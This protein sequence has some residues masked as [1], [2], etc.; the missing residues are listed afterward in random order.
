MSDRKISST[1]GGVRCMWMRGGTSKGGYF[2]AD[3]LPVDSA[4][5]D[6]FL[7]RV[8]GSPDGRQIDGMGGANPLTSK[9]AVVKKSVREG[10]DVGYLFLQIFVDRPIVTDQQNC[11]NILAGVGPFAIERGLVSPQNGLTEVRIFMENTGQT[12]SPP[13]RRPAAGSAMTDRPISTAFRGRLRRSRSSL[14]IRRARPA[15]R[16]CRPATLSI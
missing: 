4:V 1:E 13:S 11:G 3:D 15:A 16:C 14:R 8:M 2:L 7:L 5:R 6:A 9:V 12:A 10:A